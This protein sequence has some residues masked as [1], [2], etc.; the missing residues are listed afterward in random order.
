METRKNYCKPLGERVTDLKNNIFFK[1]RLR[2]ASYYVIIIALLLAI[3]ST[4]LYFSYAKNIQ[5]DIEG[6]FPDEQ[7]Q[8]VIV[9]KTTD[10]LQEQLV[11][12][13]AVVVLFVGGFGYWLAGKTLKPIQKTL[14]SQ[15]RFIADASHELRTPLTILKTDLEVALR[16]K[17]STDEHSAILT[18]NLEEVERM[19]RIVEDLLMLSRIDN[20]QEILQFSKT[21]IAGLMQKSVKRMKKYAESRNVC[22]SASAEGPVYVLGDPDKLQQALSNVL[23][24][25]IDYSKD[26][27]E[28]HISLTK[29]DR[30]AN[31]VVEDN[32]IGISADDLTHIFDRFYRADK[33]RS[34]RQ[35][36]SGL[37]LPIIKWIIQKHHGN[38]SVQSSPDKG[39]KLTI[40]LPLFKTAHYSHF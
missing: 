31:I 5:N 30:Q 7:A 19:R 37:G 11:I 18:S 34:R 24:N 32:G 9:S 27:G 39:T 10:R 14:D 26:K 20:D 4:F 21:D 13:D 29:A 8:A 25:A 16:S 6:D 33:S 35:G 22:I 40:N 36:G 17:T 38:I 3:F 1:A 2:L 23:K 12:V 28:V 15:K